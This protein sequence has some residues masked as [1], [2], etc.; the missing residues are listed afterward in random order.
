MKTQSLAKLKKNLDQVF[1]RYIRQ[2]YARNGLVNCYTCTTIKPPEQMQNGHWIPRNNLATRFSESNCR[3]QCVG[4]N[5]FNRGRPDVFS[6]NLIKEGVDIVELQKS[7]YAIFKV[8]Q[9]WYEDKIKHYQT[10]LNKL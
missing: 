6:V 5:M 2:K 1:S 4:C 3:P 10:E 7:R 8:D 9:G